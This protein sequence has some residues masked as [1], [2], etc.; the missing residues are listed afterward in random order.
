MDLLPLDVT[1]AGYTAFVKTDAYG[2]VNEPGEEDNNTGQS[3][4]LLQVTQAPVADLQVTQ[5]QGLALVVA[6]QTV[7][8]G[9]D[10]SQ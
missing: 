6:G 7:T 5:V 4:G 8:I 9:W 3:I 1:A 2:Y 10:R